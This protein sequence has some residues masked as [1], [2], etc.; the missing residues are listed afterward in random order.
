M[1]SLCV[2]PV[3]NEEKRLQH[4]LNE[5][6]KV[7]NEINDLEFLIIN[8]GSTDKSNQIISKFQIKSIHFEKNNGVG[9]ALIKGLEYAVENNFEI[10]LHMAG[11]GKMLPSEIKNFLIKI[12]DNFDFVNGSRFLPSANY[13]NNPKNRVIMIKI[14]SLFISLVYKRKI[15]DVTCGFRAFKVDLFKNNLKFFNQKRFFTYR[16]EYYTYGKILRNIKY[17]CTE[18]PVTMDYPKK[19]YSK[20]RPVIDWIPIIFGWLEARFDGK[21]F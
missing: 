5:V 17:N 4:L 11:N 10:I 15:T 14:L 9:F 3:Y 20:I 2:I 13:K 1:R 19:N 18:I 12:N 21:K 16:Y 8:N 6:T 7:K